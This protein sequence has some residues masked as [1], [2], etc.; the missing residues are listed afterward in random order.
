MLQADKQNKKTP[1]SRKMSIR[2]ITV[3][4][5]AFCMPTIASAFDVTGGEV[6]IGHSVFIDD[7]DFARSSLEGSVELGFSKSIGVQVDAGISSFNVISE[8]ST[9]F[10]VH[11]IYHFN[12]ATS[13]GVFVGTEE[14]ASESDAFYGA[15]VGTEFT[16]GDIEGYVEFGEDSGVDVT[17]IGLSGSYQL[18]DTFALGASVDYVE[19]D[20][21]IDLTRVGVRGDYAVG[22]QTDLYAEAGSLSADAFGLTGSEA[23]VGVGAEFN[24]GAERGATFGR[25]GLARLLPGL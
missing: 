25:R 16:Q 10:A 4:A 7:T 17:V 14:L 5:C 8:T 9:A 15:E 20:G 1:R 11:G 19:F 22:Q 12:E 18:N 24:F 3:V 6:S 23:F 21:G 2:T 13:A